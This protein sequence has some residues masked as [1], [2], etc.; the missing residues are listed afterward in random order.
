MSAYRQRWNSTAYKAIDKR[1]A[2]ATA[3]CVHQRIQNPSA[4]SE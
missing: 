4:G 2:M 1:Q 3:N